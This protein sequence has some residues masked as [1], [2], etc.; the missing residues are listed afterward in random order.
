MIVFSY[1]NTSSL[2]LFTLVFVFFVQ[3]KVSFSSFILFIDGG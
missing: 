1:Y 2:V 3:R